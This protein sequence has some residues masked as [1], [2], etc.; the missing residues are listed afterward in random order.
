MVAGDGLSEGPTAGRRLPGPSHR[1]SGCRAPILEQVNTA[2]NAIPPT[3][4]PTPARSAPHPANLHPV[5]SPV[6]VGPPRQQR[7]A[8]T[9]AV[10]SGP[11]R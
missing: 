3:L 1:H 8:G 11:Q 7:L 4:H 5:T 10:R 9:Q 6:R 2:P